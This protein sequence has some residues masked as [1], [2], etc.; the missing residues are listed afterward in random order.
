MDIKAYGVCVYVL[1]VYTYECM[2][3]R[4]CVHVYVC[5][6]ICVCV[7]ACILQSLK[8]G[9]IILYFMYLIDSDNKTSMLCI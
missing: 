5:V 4:V 3:I 1:C 2:Y 9:I 6:S 7:H 8:S